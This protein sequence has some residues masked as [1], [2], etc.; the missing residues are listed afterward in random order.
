MNEMFKHKHAEAMALYAEDALKSKTPWE[1]WELRLNNTGEWKKCTFTPTWN[2]HFEYRRVGTK[3]VSEDEYYLLG[4]VFNGKYLLTKIGHGQVRLI[5]MTTGNRQCDENIRASE[6]FVSSDSD[7]L[8]SKEDIEKNLGEE[9]KTASTFRSMVSV[10]PY[11]REKMK[12]RTRVKTTTMNI[13]KLLPCPFCGGANIALHSYTPY[14]HFDRVFPSVICHDCY[15]STSGQ[16][17][18]IDGKSA[19]ESW[20]RRSL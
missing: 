14:D 17:W 7:L 8:F 9:V 11:P 5:N 2:E 13:D 1:R 6:E 20:N 16:K 4:T 15:A 18:D 19:I 3:K 10:S 12:P